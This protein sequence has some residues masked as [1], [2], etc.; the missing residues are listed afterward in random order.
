MELEKQSATNT[1]QNFD[2]VRIK[3]ALEALRQAQMDEKNKETDSEFRANM[4][5][6]MAA[7][8]LRDKTIF[9]LEQ[10]LNCF[11]TTRDFSSVWTRYCR[12]NTSL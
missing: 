6:M 9:M 2:L 1:E 10:I 8:S 11:D 5:I 12:E 7:K 4:L 3:K